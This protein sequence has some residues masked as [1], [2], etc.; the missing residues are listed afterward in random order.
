MQYLLKMST[1][2][3]ITLPAETHLAEEV[4]LK[5]RHA[6][7][8]QP[9]PWGTVFHEELKTLSYNTNYTIRQV[10]RIIIIIIIIIHNHHSIPLNHKIKSNV[11]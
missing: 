2:V 5:L 7:N 4:T 11:I 1:F 6:I 10:P 8:V 9:V 3:P